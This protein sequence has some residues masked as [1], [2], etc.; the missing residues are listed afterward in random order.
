MYDKKV[1]N[2]FCRL[3]NVFVQIAKCIVQI[4]ISIILKQRH[5]DGK[6]WGVS[7]SKS[8]IRKEDSTTAFGSFMNSILNISNTQKC[9]TLVA[10]A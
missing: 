7:L 9:V 8:M 10:S 5:P 3:Q 2:V 1:Q 4:V 6:S